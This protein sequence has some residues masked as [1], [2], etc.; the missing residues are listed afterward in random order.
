MC[1]MMECVVKDVVWGNRN[2]Q[3]ALNG[4]MGHYILACME[5]LCCAAATL[6]FSS[7]FP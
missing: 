5:K 6:N 7:S 3:H 1:T 4:G 2:I